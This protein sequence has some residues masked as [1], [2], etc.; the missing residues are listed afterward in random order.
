MSDPK[1]LRV[2]IACGGTGG[3]LFPGIAIAESLREEGYEAAVVVSEKKIDEIAME[4]HPEIPVFKLPA[5]ATP[6][7]F[8]PKIILFGARFAQALW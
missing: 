7:Y 1:K 4:S 3:H 6:S 2:L 8:S 5:I